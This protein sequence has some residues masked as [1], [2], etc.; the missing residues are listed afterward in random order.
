MIILAAVVWYLRLL[1]VHLA[2]GGLRLV[3][4]LHG[5]MAANDRD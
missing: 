4:L 2:G 5:L 3:V 1:R